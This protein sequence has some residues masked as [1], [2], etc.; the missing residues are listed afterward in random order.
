MLGTRE[1]GPLWASCKDEVLIKVDLQGNGVLLRPWYKR[2]L[3]TSPTTLKGLP[4]KSSGIISH[5][6]GLNGSVGQQDRRV[7]RCPLH[8]AL[9]QTSGVRFADRKGLSLA[10][11]PSNPAAV[12]S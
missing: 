10:A 11:S 3:Y 2:L 5:L 1:A 7:E 6:T 12:P 8:S 9:L 4:V